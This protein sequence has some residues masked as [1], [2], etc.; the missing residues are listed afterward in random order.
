MSTQPKLRVCKTV[1]ALIKELQKLPPSIKLSD[2]MRPVKYNYG[3]SA[4]DAGLKPCV[5]FE[6]Y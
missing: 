3:K 4:K 6:D 1:G 5:G 2:P